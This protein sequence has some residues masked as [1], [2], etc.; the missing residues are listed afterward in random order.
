MPTK[1][2]QWNGVLERFGNHFPLLVQHFHNVCPMVAMAII[3]GVILF[4]SV[5]RS[6]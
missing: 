2:D 6:V 4:N 1:S 5:L 3:G